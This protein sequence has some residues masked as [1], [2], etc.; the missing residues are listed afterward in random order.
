MKKLVTMMLCI[1]GFTSMVNAVTFYVDPTNGVDTRDGLS[2]AGAVK[3]ISKASTLAAANSGVDN[4]Y[5]KGASTT[6]YTT[7]GLTFTAGENYYGGFFGN[8]T[9]YTQRPLLDA[10]GNG[11]VE[12][13]EFQYPTLISSTYAGYA[14]SIPSTCTVDGFSF[15]HM[16]TKTDGTSLRT[17]SCGGISSVLQNCI[18]KN[19]VLSV[20]LTS[21]SLSGILMQA[22]GVLKTCLFEKNQVSII[23]TGDY[24][25][26]PML[27]VLGNTKV[28]SCV[29]RNNK[30]TM[31][32]SASTTTNATARGLMMCIAGGATATPSAHTTVSNCLIFNNEMIYVPNASAATMSAGATICMNAY[33]TSVTTDSLI[34]CMVANNKGTL[35]A[36]SGLTVAASG[37]AVHWVYNNVLWN[38]QVGGVVKNVIVNSNP[39]SGIIAN[40][41]MNAGVSGGLATTY[42]VNNLWNMGTTNTNDTATVSPKFKNPTL[43]IGNATDGSVETADWRLNATSYLI[44]KGA[45][46]TVLTDKM[47]SSFATTHSVGAYEY[48]LSSGINDVNDQSMKLINV[49]KHAIIANVDGTLQL[50]SLTGQVLKSLQVTSGQNIELAAGVYIVRIQSAKGKFA[51]TV[52][53]Y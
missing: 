35:I 14:F 53:L 25:V 40:N 51:Q 24:Y 28:S 47:G 5:I 43:V 31:D 26:A 8:E 30:V 4:I 23:A 48:T 16:A 44:G 11:I 6:S 34:N 12:P 45:I 7:S 52:E 20:A 3:T 18:I 13:W 49:T 15:T 50:F 19:S 42:K 27:D 39:T 9:S 2:W 29:L 33:S 37:S 46:T 10:D 17:V 41:V 1:A 36:N 22:Q 38:N 32:Y 21:S